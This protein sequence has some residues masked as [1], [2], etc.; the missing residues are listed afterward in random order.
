MNLQKY[1]VLIAVTLLL[2]LGHNASATAETRV[3]LLGTG[4]PQPDPDRSGPATA[5]VVDG[6]AYLVD[7]GPGVVRRAAEAARD[8][9]LPSLSPPRLRV[10]FSTHLHSD[11]TAG[12]PDLILTPWVM[13]RQGPLEVFGPKGLKD[14][15]DH[16]LAAYREDIRI[17]TEG[18]E[19]IDVPC[20]VE[21]HEIGPG[22]IY[23]DTRVTVTAF[24]TQHGDW[25]QSF[26]YR[27]DTADRRV[28]ITGDTTP[29]QA[30][31]DACDGCDIL[32]HEALT[33]KFLTNPMRPNRQN[34]DIQDYAKAY[35][36]TTA[37]L[38]EL[39]DKAHP[40]LLILTHN[41]IT[42]R[43]EKRPLAS[44]Q[45]DLLREIKDA[46]YLGQVVVGHDLDIY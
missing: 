7:F 30:T 41:P 31:I 29:V 36:T 15:T 13:G 44:T 19:K 17:R 32:I 22:V 40:K 5:V 24:P 27:F 18:M 23:K 2:A 4:N 14:M 33:I 21:V 34:F 3:V 46:G 38:A 9:H 26:G 10:A 25:S 11:H 28:V 42:L 43:P 39:A 45:E 20:R 16:L 35:H 1:S 12:Y 8:L 6:Y 37:Q